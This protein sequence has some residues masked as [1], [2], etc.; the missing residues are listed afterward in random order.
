MRMVR[1]IVS[2]P[3]DVPDAP[4][5]R[6][7]ADTD[8]GGFQPRLGPSLEG[9]GVEYV[10][11]TS[12]EFQ[13]RFQEFADWKTRL[14]VPT[15]VRTLPWIEQNYPGGAD[16]AE[17][18]RFFIQDAYSTWGTTYVLLGGDTG[19]VP[20]RLIYSSYQGGEMIPADIYFSSLEG[21]WN[22]DGDH[23]F[24]EGTRG[25]SDPGD[26]VDLYP[27]VFVGRAPVSDIVELETFISKCHAY[28]EAPEVAFTDRNLFL[29]EVLF[30]YD[31]ESGPFSLDGA[32]HIAEPAL[33]M[34]PGD[35]HLTRLYANHEA[36]PESEPLG[37]IRSGC[38]VLRQ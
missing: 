18:M 26:N 27:D 6:A 31:W 38:P 10:I 15:V 19:V 7:A 21:D 29:A 22:G 2:N 12:D 20:E 9:S 13:S 14:G 34:F 17:R 23:L 36:F 24:G 11:I 1:S 37:A 28:V 32:T 30:P 5:S 35:L 8:G 33:P 25:V 3:E 16:V 4:L